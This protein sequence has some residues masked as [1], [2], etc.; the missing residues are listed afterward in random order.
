M[1]FRWLLIFF[2]NKLI[3]WHPQY[4][5][6]LMIACWCRRLDKIDVLLVLVYVSHIG[7]AW[8]VWVS[9][10]SSRLS[11]PIMTLLGDS[12]KGKE[13]DHT[14]RPEYWG[15]A[16]LQSRWS[17]T[18]WH[19]S[20][21]REESCGHGPPRPCR[22]SV[23]HIIHGPCPTQKLVRW[24]TCKSFSV[25]RDYS[26]DFIFTCLSSMPDLDLLCRYL[27]ILRAW[28]SLGEKKE[29]R[30]G[31]NF[32]R[33]ADSHTH[34]PQLH[35][36]GR[37][38][39]PAWHVPLQWPNE[40]WP[41]S[42]ATRRRRRRNPSRIQLPAATNYISIPVEFS[43]SDTAHPMHPECITWFTLTKRFW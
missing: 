6:Q 19:C 24:Q 31:L 23:R 12:N 37:H 40:T 10:I 29:S 8:W 4:L 38:C 32:T 5:Y 17:L 30:P 2:C 26:V 11:W 25:Y 14:W 13:I 16:S 3:L 22:S 27:H 15:H 21:Q 35:E 43:S 1:W 20:V 9:A 28:S 42:T 7:K 33:P 34:H 36:S 18:A 41:Q 39:L